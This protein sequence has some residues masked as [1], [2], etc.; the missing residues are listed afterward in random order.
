MDP[1]GFLTRSLRTS[2]HGEQVMRILSAA[3]HAVEPG[4]AVRRHMQRDGTRIFI[5]NQYY[6]FDDLNRVLVV[7]FGKAS[8]PMAA[9]T[10]EIL[11]DKI[12]SG[13]AITNIIAQIKADTLDKT[14]QGSVNHLHKP[15]H[16]TF[17]S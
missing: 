10:S 5:G 3:I 13:F 7:G 17:F 2:S 14:S 11:G 15:V 12:Y 8:L 9:A 4:K 16:P 6:D 1:K